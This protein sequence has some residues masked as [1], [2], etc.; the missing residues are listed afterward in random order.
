MFYGGIVTGQIRAIE[1][2][3]GFTE[4]KTDRRIYR[5]E[6]IYD[7]P[8]KTQINEIKVADAVYIDWGS[9]F[10]HKVVMIRE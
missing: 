3:I 8:V 7:V 6:N 2:G 5:I 4:I 1:H 10:I 9:G